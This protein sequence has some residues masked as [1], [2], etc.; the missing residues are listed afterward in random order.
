M[1]AVIASTCG[2]V[3]LGYVVYVAPLLL[4]EIAV[5]A[6]LVGAIYGRLR[7]RDMRTWLHT[8]VARTWVPALA[9]VRTVAIL[10]WGLQRVAPG[11]ASIGA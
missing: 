5:D 1:L 11:A 3:A 4:A 10:G 7:K 6:A 2:V 8:A 9:V